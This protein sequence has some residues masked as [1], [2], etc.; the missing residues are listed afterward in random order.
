MY[1]DA[2]TELA[3]WLHALDNTNYSRWIP[4]HLKD[5]AN[6]DKDNQTWTESLEFSFTVHETTIQIEQVH[7]QNNAYLKLDGGAVGLTDHPSALR[8]WMIVGPLRM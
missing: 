5:M 6:I 3:A 2:L 1:L 4:F 8:R 7:E